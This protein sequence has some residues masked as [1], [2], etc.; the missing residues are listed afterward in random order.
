MSPQHQWINLILFYVL[1][2]GGLLLVWYGVYI[3]LDEFADGTASSSIICVGVL[4][5]AASAVT[6]FRDL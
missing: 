6:L 5:V 3:Q 2:V 1:F 4:M